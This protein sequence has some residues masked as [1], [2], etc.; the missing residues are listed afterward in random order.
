MVQVAAPFVAIWDGHSSWSI[1]CF[2]RPGALLYQW[3]E[4]DRICACCVL[5]SCCPCHADLLANGIPQNAVPLRAALVGPCPPQSPSSVW[6]LQLTDK[7][8]WAIFARLTPFMIRA[9][10]V[11]ACATLKACD[12]L[13]SF[14]NFSKSCLEQPLTWRFP[15]SMCSVVPCIL[16]AWRAR[17]SL[18]QQGFKKGLGKT[19]DVCRV[20][21]CESRWPGM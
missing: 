3:R 2:R 5:S 18:K 1:P 13:I 17:G 10:T 11:R 8:V 14:F 12:T 4:V 20:I 15:A 7:P 21:W 16:E 19:S 6:W 9:L